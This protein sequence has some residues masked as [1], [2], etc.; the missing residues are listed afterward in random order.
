MGYSCNA[1]ASMCLDALQEYTKNQTHPAWKDG[2][3]TNGYLS[4]KN[5]PCFLE[6][7]RENR[8]GSITGSVFENTRFE[9]GIPLYIKK[10]SFKITAEGIDRMYGLTPQ[11][12]KHINHLAREIYA[13]TYQYPYISPSEKREKNRA[14]FNAD[15]RDYKKCL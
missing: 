15:T 9:N 11:E 12:K 5:L 4:N 13:R 7:G 10:S 3:P 6:R 2:K 14:S 8:D 1:Y